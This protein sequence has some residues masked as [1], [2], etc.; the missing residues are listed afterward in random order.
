[1]QENKDLD[2]K[3][4][5]MYPQALQVI[6]KLQS[7]GFVAVIAG[8]AVRDLLMQRPQ[9]AF[10]DIDVATN[11]RPEQVESLFPKTVAVGKSFGVIRVIQDEFSIEVATF[12]K[13]SESTDG[14]H[15]DSIE[16][17]N[18]QED[19]LRRDFTVNALFYDPIKKQLFDSVGGLIDLQKKILRAVG[20]PQAR[21]SEDHL[22]RLRLLRFI[23]Q[24]GFQAD[25]STAQA[26]KSGVEGLQKVSRERVTA[27]IEKMW[28]G[29]YLKLAWSLFI[30]SGVAEQIDPVWKTADLPDWN[31]TEKLRRVSP[32][33]CYFYHLCRFN[34]VEE[35]LVRLKL[36]RLD[37]NLILSAQGLWSEA[38]SFLK[39]RPGLQ[40][41]KWKFSMTEPL[42]DLYFSKHP[43]KK[44]W[45]LLRNKLRDWGPVPAPLFMGRDLMHE[46]KGPL[47][48]KLLDD[49]YVM[50]LEENWT[51]QD[52]ADSFIANW[53][54]QHPVSN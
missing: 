52:Q 46:C 45:D 35:S 54:S 47:L 29:P 30:D 19:A 24:L 53:K 12:R 17:S 14:R 1:M 2:F 3:A 25:P 9:S 21:F 33:L 49:L 40:R 15:P 22:R 13:D 18:Q 44:E 11:A 23:S 43:Q 16:Y 7:Q 50:Q 28:K 42:L 41:M 38:G 6:E 5:Q 48:G 27:E 20:N 34:R 36:S 51:S 4:V 26:L 31:Q 39:L 10:I 32:W 37:Q 8:G